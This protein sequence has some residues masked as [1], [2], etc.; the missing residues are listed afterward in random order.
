MACKRGGKVKLAAFL[1]IFIAFAAGAS[2]SW[3]TYQND[4]R[5]SGS[6]DEV[7]YFPL[8]TANF[9]VD[10][11]GTNFQSLADDLDND[12]GKEIVIFS[13]NSLILF[14]SQLQILNQ[15]KVGRILGQPVL[16][17]Y[18]DEGHIDIIFNARQ[19]STDYFFAYSFKESSLKQEFNI[20]LPYGAN[21]SGIKC[22]KLDNVDS[23]VFKDKK[24]YVHIID[25]ESKNDSYYNTSVYEEPRHTVPAIDDIDNDGKMDAVFWFNADNTSGYGFLA[26]D[27]SQR[28][29][30]WAVDNIFSPLVYGNDL[31]QQVFQLKG[32]PVLVDLNGDNKLEIA[33]SAFY[34][35]SIVGYDFYTDQFTE[36]FVYSHNGTKLFSKCGSIPGLPGLGCNDGIDTRS[37]WEGTNPFVLDYDKDGMDEICFVKDVKKGTR[38]SYM[39]LNCYNHSGNEIANVNLTNHL[40][41]IR[42]TAIL[43]DM[44]NDGE[45]ELILSREVYLLNGTS[46]FSM[47]YFDTEHSIAVDVDGNGGLDLV[48]TGG[49][50]TKLF[51]DGNNYLID[52]GVGDSDI[53]FSNFNETH[54]GVNAVIRN[55]G[56]LEAKNVKVIAYNMNTLENN[57]AVFDLKGNSNVTFSSVIEVGRGENVLVSVDYDNEIRESDETNNFAIREFD[58][59]PY[60]YF[61]I[62]E[63]E[64]NLL[65]YLEPII[66]EYMKNS[67]VAGY[68]TGNEFD[69]DVVVYIGKNN[70]KNKFNNRKF[71]NEF[72]IGYDFGNIIYN[73]EVGINPYSALVAGFEENDTFGKPRHI[74]MIAG[75]EI[76]GDIAVIKEFIRNQAAFVNSQV[77]LFVDDEDEEAIRIYDYLHLGG[78]QEHYG[79]MDNEFRKIVGNA[80]NDRMFNEMNFEVTTSNDVDLRLKNLKPNISDDYLEY[81][82]SNGMPVEM[83]VVISRGIHSNL[84]TWENLASELANTGRDTWMIEITGGPNEECDDCPNYNFSDL[85]ENYWPTLINGVLNFTG[86]EKIQ[87][88]GHSNGGRVA[89]VSLENGVIDS[90]KIETFIGVAVP[91]AFE[92]Y[93]TFGNYFGKYGGQIME[94]LEGESHVS[95][96][97]IGDKLSAIC[98]SNVDFSCRIFSFGLKSDN[99]MSFNVDKQY[100]FWVINNSDEQIGKNLQL[101]NFY[102]IQGWIVDNNTTNVSHDFIVTEQDENAIYDNIISANKK[103]YKLWGAHT[104]GWNSASVP[105]RDLTKSIIKDALNKKPLNRYESNEINST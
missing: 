92:G 43:A 66:L 2:A 5:N 85:T 36:L 103:H 94:E 54:I 30:K 89:I 58:G 26:F 102:I 55:S 105:D 45:K 17:D 41:G 38:F 88:V 98:R 56:Q 16:F 80:L 40:G 31:S 86:K 91:S 4:L 21:L 50:M 49:N 44:N 28:K 7:G 32:Q 61:S 99:K 69:A 73:D 11:L 53:T 67:L 37:G 34:D 27:L 6:S 3:Q 65:S 72:Q 95:M 104:A 33:A 51:L 83:P 25:M 76:E 22:L 62:K 29:T 1:I 10:G 35:D 46:I 79:K 97:E 100:Y 77:S 57:T 64:F 39:A 81:L 15:A 82:S 74:V 24:N 9:S 87:Y 42:G 70:V 19:N 84:T 63:E 59:L 12:G 75:N 96:T 52:L 18:D 93:S 13:N 14:D 48:W 8:E 23:C 90:D 71:L 20:T 47:H 68:Y 101:D 78:N 60:V